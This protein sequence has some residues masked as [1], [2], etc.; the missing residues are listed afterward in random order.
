[1][2]AILFE[3]ALF[4]TV[5][6]LFARSSLGLSLSSGFLLGGGGWS[7][8]WKC[9]TSPS[10]G[11]YFGNASPCR[12]RS[13]FWVGGLVYRLFILG[14]L[15]FGA[16]PLFFERPSAPKSQRFLRFA[17]AM[18]IADPRNR[19]DLR[20]KRKQ[21]CPDLPKIPVR[22]KKMSGSYFYHTFYVWFRF[23]PENKAYSMSG[24]GLP[25]RIRHILQTYFMSGS[26][27]D[28]TCFPDISYVWFR[29]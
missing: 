17:I 9:P 29:G 11:F 25:K 12:H 22:R 18:P 5:F 23:F 20:D 7:L 3:G 10:T 4:Q 15:G 26:G 19:S 8:A 6:S 28:Q 2:G 16:F 27:L 13:F 24:S 21:C 14:G 1:M